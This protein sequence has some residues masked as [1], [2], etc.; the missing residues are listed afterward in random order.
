MRILTL[1]PNNIG[2]G[3]LI[4]VNPSHPIRREPAHEDLVPVSADYPLILMGREPAK[5]LRTVT[6]LLDLE[7]RV[8]P[9]SGFRTMQEQKAIYKDSVRDNGGDFTQ[10]YVAIPGCSEHQTGLA[11]DL[12]EDRPDIDFIRPDL[13]STGVFK[14]FREMLPRYGFIERYQ[15]KWEAVTRISYEPW[16]FR[17]VG[18]PHSELITEKGLP[19]EGYLD[20]LKRFPSEGPHLLLF[21]DKMRFEIF[22]VSRAD[23]PVQVKIPEKTRYQVSGDNQDGFVVT[24]WR[25]PA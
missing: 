11:I 22:H 21:C 4:L 2:K 12:A 17:Y 16:H 23:K 15:A 3:N 18:Y 1:D 5:M 24:L 9:V 8:A 19:L 13:P 7:R 20:Y 25:T 14:T 6:A 10:K